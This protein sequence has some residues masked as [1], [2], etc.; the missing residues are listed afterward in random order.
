MCHAGSSQG[1]YAAD[2]DRSASGVGE[3]RDLRPEYAIRG[4]YISIR[5]EGKAKENYGDGHLTV[6]DGKLFVEPDGKPYGGS[7]HV[8][9]LHVEG[10]GESLA[11]PGTPRKLFIPV[12][13]GGAGG[14][15]CQ[16]GSLAFYVHSRGRVSSRRN[17]LLHQPPGHRGL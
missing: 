8:R 2:R 3:G 12:H 11:E 7:T 10:R 9:F 14:F 4:R 17:R 1:K 16:R 13:L 6:R 5:L 15:G